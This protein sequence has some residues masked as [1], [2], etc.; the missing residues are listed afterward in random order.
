MP[1]PRMKNILHD[2]SSK[3]PLLPT[4]TDNNIIWPQLLAKALIQAFQDDLSLPLL[5]CITALTGWI[6]YQLCA[7]HSFQAN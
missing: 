2:I 3:A 6:P 1:L 5:P 7:W 4:S